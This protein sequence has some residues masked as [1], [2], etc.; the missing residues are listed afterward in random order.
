MEQMV[1]DQDKVDDFTLALMSL[2][3]HRD[4]DA[5][6]AWKG[7]DWETLDR[8]YEKGMISNPKGR[9]RSVLITEEGLK[10]SEKL[11]RELFGK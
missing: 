10:K 6:R 9:A 5:T 1:Y 8:L 7:F 11:F 2:V 4:K 3:F